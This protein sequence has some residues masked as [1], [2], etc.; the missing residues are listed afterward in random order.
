MGV[1]NQTKWVRSA[2]LACLV[3][4]IPPMAQAQQPKLQATVGAYY[5]DGW[6]GKTENMHLPKL[7]QTKYADR[8]PLWGWR[9]DTVEIMQKQIDYCADH[10]IAF[11]AFDW[12]YP[13]GEDKTT[14]LNNALGLYLK[15]PNSQRLKFC[16]LVANHAGFRI[17][18]KEWDACCQRWIDL[19]QQPTHLRLDGQPLLIFFSP[20]ELKRAFGGVEDVRQALE[21]L[22]SKAKQAG[23]P[24]VAVAAC[25]GPGSLKELADSGYSLLTGYN[26]NLGWQSGGGSQPFQKLVEGNQ[27][28]FEQFAEKTPLPYVP[29]VTIGWDRRPWEEE[30]L[31]SE[32]MSTWYPD[33]TPKLVEEFVRLGVIWLDKHP[34]KATAQRLMLLYAW[35]E[36]GEGGYLTPTEKDGIEYLEA[37]ERAISGNR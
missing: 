26:Y 22:R 5:F 3:A 37:V 27:R 33:R 28:I 17:G 15:A 20:E 10:D 36:N 32:K 7:L 31:P 12:Y 16:L 18:P 23:L 29:V 21:T 2:V 11:W 4:L 35:N 25:T 24:G 9:A 14:P 6:S 34:D 19:F 13:E 8:K 1:S 30:K